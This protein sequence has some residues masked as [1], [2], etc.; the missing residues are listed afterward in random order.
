MICFLQAFSNGNISLTSRKWYVSI[1]KCMQETSITTRKWYVSI[2][3]WK[4]ISYDP[5]KLNVFSNGN[6]SL[7][8]DANCTHFLMETYHLRPLYTFHNGNASLTIGVGCRPM[9]GTYLLYKGS[10]NYLIWHK[11]IRH[12]NFL[13]ASYRSLLLLNFW[14]RR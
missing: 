6:I 9:R 13:L 1:R 10:A 14:S 4:Q 8:T 11:I 3:K 12:K 2:R 5:C 7:T